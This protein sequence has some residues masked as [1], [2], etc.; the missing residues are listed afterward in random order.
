M[1]GATVDSYRYRNDDEPAAIHES[2]NSLGD[3]L[4]NGG[5]LANSVKALAEPVLKRQLYV[6]K[7]DS[8]AMNS[9]KCHI[10]SASELGIAV[11]DNK[12]ISNLGV[13]Q[14]KD[15]IYMHFSSRGLSYGNVDGAVVKG[16]SL[17]GTWL[18]DTYPWE[19]SLNAHP[20]LAVSWDGAGIEVGTPMALRKICPCFCL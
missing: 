15:E 20:P 16:M 1:M 6:S 4:R 5:Q 10:L 13:G 7:S 17:P 11:T 19:G 2:G 8:V 14:N 3:F 9:G 18:R 12:Q